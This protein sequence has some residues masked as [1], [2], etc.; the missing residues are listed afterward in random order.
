M[1]LGLR[2]ARALAYLRES[3]VTSQQILSQ[4]S[5]RNAMV[6]HAACGGSTNLILH[7]TAIAYHAGLSR[8]TVEDWDEINR[9][10]PRIVDVLPNGPNNYTT[11][12]L[13]LA[14]GVPEI[15]VKLKEKNLL[16]LQV[17]TVTGQT[18]GE[19]SLIH[20]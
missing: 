2:S 20:I 11:A 18:I 14:G 8:P 3:N 16:D 9:M 12:Q 4:A 17:L 10:V 6:V 13:F 19:L 7:L 15:M 1:E 5:I